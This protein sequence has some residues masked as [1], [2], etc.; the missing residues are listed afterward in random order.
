MDKR[1]R[2]RTVDYYIYHK[3]QELNLNDCE[4]ELVVIE[5]FDDGEKRVDG[6]R[7]DAKG[8]FRRVE[9]LGHRYMTMKLK[10]ADNG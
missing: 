2:S 1:D 8:Y 3:G 4:I 10:E 6:G 7:Q 5:D 9:E